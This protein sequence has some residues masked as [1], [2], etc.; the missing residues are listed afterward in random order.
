MRAGQKI[1]KWNCYVTLL[2]CSSLG[3]NTTALKCFE[4]ASTTGCRWTWKGQRKC[5]YRLLLLPRWVVRLQIALIFCNWDL[6]SLTSFCWR[7]RGGYG[8]RERHHVAC[9][10]WGR[11]DD[12]RVQVGQARRW[13]GHCQVWRLLLQEIH[14]GLLSFC[15]TY[16]ALV[17]IWTRTSHVKEGACTCREWRK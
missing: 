2:V 4:D 5:L 17:R 15:G 7:F 6:G 13:V 11:Q 3:K 14:T 1:I 16:L 8:H 9:R 10:H 12:G